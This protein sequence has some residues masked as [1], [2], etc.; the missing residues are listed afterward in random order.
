MFIFAADCLT[1]DL[2]DMK[3]NADKDIQE[4]PV[5]DEVCGGKV[6]DMG[7]SMPDDVAEQALAEFEDLKKK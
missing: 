5:T 1:F 6:V 7:F 3:E 4:M 2:T